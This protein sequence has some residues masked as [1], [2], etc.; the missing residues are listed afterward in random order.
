[1]SRGW[2]W[3]YIFFAGRSSRC[4]GWARCHITSSLSGTSRAARW[5]F[6]SH[7]A[8]TTEAVLSATDR[9]LVVCNPRS[10]R[11]APCR[12]GLGQYRALMPWIL[13]HELGVQ[14]TFKD[15][16]N[17]TALLPYVFKE[18]HM[19][20]LERSWDSIHKQTQNCVSSVICR[21]LPKLRRFH[22][23]LT[24]SSSKVRNSPLIRS[25]S[26]S[27][28]ISER[29]F[30]CHLLIPV[31]STILFQSSPAFGVLPLRS[32]SIRQP[33]VN[34]NGLRIL[35]RAYDFA[36]ERCMSCTKSN[37]D[38]GFG[39]LSGFVVRYII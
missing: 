36:A 23:V 10:L 32:Q 11:S 18:M 7:R 8:C 17:R 14:R 38:Y 13:V 4:G 22:H 25:C 15:D 28:T 27:F 12:Q 26:R 39:W 29:P 35:S 20:H 2:I 6:S 30:H 37:R 3:S 33:Y 16:R 9:R 31:Q 24:G 5:L 19:L 34:R 21:F 1:M